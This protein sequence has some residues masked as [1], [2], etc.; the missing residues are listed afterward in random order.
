MKN[1]PDLEERKDFAKRKAFCSK[2]LVKD[3]KLS[4]FLGGNPIYLFIFIIFIVNLTLLSYVCSRLS[5]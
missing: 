5:F 2:C 1:C 3:I 4:S